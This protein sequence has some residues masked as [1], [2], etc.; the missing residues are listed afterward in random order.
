[1]RVFWVRPL[2]CVVVTTWRERL[3]EAIAQSG[4]KQSVIALDAGVTPETLS[5]ILN[6]INQRPGLETVTR[7]A[8]AVHENVGWLLGEHGFMLSTRQLAELRQVVNFLNTA[9]LGAPPPNVVVQSN[10]NAM[11]IR[12][13]VPRDFAAAGA[14]R[15]FQITDDSMSGAA[16]ADGDLL[17]VQPQRDLRAARGR[18]VVAEDAGLLYAKQLEIRGET[19]RLVSRNERYAPVETRAAELKLVGVVVG[20]CGAPVEGRSASV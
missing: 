6:D 1:M 12:R 19:L 20:R 7:I 3:R 16:I 13:R 17:F 4:Q 2:L 11:R 14:T 5:R 15:C 10:P 8:H 18:V 9:L